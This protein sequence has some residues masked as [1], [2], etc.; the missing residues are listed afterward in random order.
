MQSLW[1][2]LSFLP[3]LYSQQSLSLLRRLHSL[4][5]FSATL[6]LCD[7]QL[8]HSTT[9]FSWVISVSLWLSSFLTA[10]R[11]QFAWLLFSSREF[12]SAWDARVK[13][14]SQPRAAAALLC[15]SFISFSLSSAS[16]IVL[17]L[18]DMLSLLFSLLVSLHLSWGYLI[19]FCSF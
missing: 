8:S 18:P 7:F 9:S 17:L 3:Y 11:F 12:Q 4:L 13:A 2:S 5:L 19:T 15:H 10:S 16:L 14:T 6:Q 1:E